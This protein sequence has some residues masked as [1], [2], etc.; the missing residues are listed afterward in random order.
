MLQ[1]DSKTTG[2]REQKIQYTAIKKAGHHSK[3]H[4][5]FTVQAKNTRDTACLRKDLTVNI[6]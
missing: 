2:K 1:I 5:H 6:R 3:R 4:P